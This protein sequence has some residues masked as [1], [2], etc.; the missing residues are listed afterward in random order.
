MEIFQKLGREVEK[1][2]R[3]KNY[4]ETLFPGVAAQALRDFNLPEKVSAWETISW[5]MGEINLPEQRDIPGRFGDPPIT[6]YNSPRFHIDIYFWLDGTTSIHQHAFCGAFQVLLGSSIHSSYEFETKEI[7][8]TFTELG[9]IDLDHCELLKVGDVRKILAGREFIHSLFHLDQP[10]ATIVVRTHRSPLHLPQFDYRKPYLAVDPFFDE[11]NL[12]KKLQTISMCFRAKRPDA[13]QML[14]NWLEIADFQ[15]T[16]TIL[17]HTKHF[18]GGNR[19][20]QFFKIEDSEDGFGKMFEIVKKRHG[21]LADMIL[22]IFAQQER[23][24]EITGRRS[25]ITEPEHRFFLALLL[26]VDG[27]ERIFSLI[28]ERFPDAEPLDKV[29]DWVSE[30]AQTRIFGSNLPNALGIEGFN[31]FDL[32]VFEDLMRGLTAE[33]IQKNAQLET[34]NG[35]AEE[36]SKNMAGR[37]EKIEQSVIL[38]PLLGN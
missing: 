8:N 26:N 27:K 4:N 12:A 30:L 14:A 34:A 33:E 16:F 19:I 25:Y 28:K 15:T 21:A 2:W 23:L 22:P 36:I 24:G 6:L 11:P 7:I 31:D 3:D 35:D 9:N 20:Q 18:L 32:F 37:I 17:S 29:L 10:S 5:A 38:K 13:E 1:L